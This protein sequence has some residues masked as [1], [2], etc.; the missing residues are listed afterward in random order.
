MSEI[1]E[2]HKAADA[3]IATMKM[4]ERCFDER[5]RLKALNAELVAALDKTQGLAAAWAG[6][7]AGK[8]GCRPG[9]LMEPHATILREATALLERA[10][11]T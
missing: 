8:N 11:A 2:A 9:Q 7:W 6:H 4:A 3:A 10:K 5:D 1:A